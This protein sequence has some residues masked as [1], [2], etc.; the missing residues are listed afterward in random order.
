MVMLVASDAQFTFTSF[1]EGLWAVGELTVDY[2]SAKD[3][4]AEVVRPQLHERP[5][6]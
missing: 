3:L 5:G 2:T 1:I 4:Y 6:A